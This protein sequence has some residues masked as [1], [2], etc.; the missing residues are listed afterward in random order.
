MAKRREKVVY[1][2]HK[3]DGLKRERSNESNEWSL[4]H[5]EQK[6]TENRTLRNTTKGDTRGREGAVTLNTERPR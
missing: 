4:V 1:R 3:G 5:D 2:Q 6:R